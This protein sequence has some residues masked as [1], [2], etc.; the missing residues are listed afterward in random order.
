[1]TDETDGAITGTWRP[2]PARAAVTATLDADLLTL[3]RDDGAEIWRLPLADVSAV[4]LVHHSIGGQIMMRLELTQDPET[5]RRLEIN[6]PVRGPSE[7]L[8]TFT[9]LIVQ[10]MR[11]LSD[12]SPEIPYT[13]GETRGISTVMVALGA[14]LAIMGGGV[15]AI[16]ISEGTVL[17][18]LI[19]GGVILVMGAG[20]AMA[21][22]A[23]AKES[24]A[25]P[26][27][28]ALEEDAGAG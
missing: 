14:T 3:A 22:L 2:A 19:A 20:I 16:M 26:L 9:T 13:L 23:S 25:R 15:A 1:M 27:A 6:H 11:K 24:P 12:L 4:R 7:P 8:K 28:K 17:Q 10:V 18:G 21:N 5:V